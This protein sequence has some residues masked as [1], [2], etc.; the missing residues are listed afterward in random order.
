M[1]T[2]EL[3]RVSERSNEPDFQSFGFIAQDMANVL[4]EIVYKPNDPDSY[5]AIDYSKITPVLVK[6]VQEQQQQIE[7]LKSASPAAASNSQTNAAI[8]SKMDE[9]T[10]QNRLL[11]EQLNAIKLQLEELKKK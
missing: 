9:L 8:Q 11:Q 5:W 1:K 2:K 4:P 7:Q 6:A 10:N 3:L